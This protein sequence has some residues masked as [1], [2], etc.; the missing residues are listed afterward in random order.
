MAARYD[1]ARRK[2]PFKAESL[3]SMELHFPPE[4]KMLASL[5]FKLNRKLQLSDHSLC[6]LLPSRN[7]PL[8]GNK[9]LFP[10]SGILRAR[11]IFH[12]RRCSAANFCNLLKR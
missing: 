8:C 10:H 4:R 9:V 7:M 5:S 12:K 11:E 3:I 1:N 6:K 2:S